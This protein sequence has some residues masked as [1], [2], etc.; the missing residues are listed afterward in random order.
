MD[1]AHATAVADRFLDAEVTAAAVAAA[2]PSA[3]A[4]AVASAAAA[5]RLNPTL[6]R[7]GMPSALVALPSRFTDLYAQLSGRTCPRTHAFPE[8]PAI[9]LLCGALL[10]AGTTCCKRHSVGALTQHVS[11]CGAGV[12]L[13]F[14]LHKCTT[15]LIRGSHAAF[16]CSPYVDEHG[17]E[18]AGLKRGRP[19]TLDPHRMAQLER[20]W[21]SHCIASEV[22]RERV[23]RERVIRENFY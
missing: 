2:T 21:A 16:C 5:A 3:L 20:L 10:C 23:T 22:V 18:D 12:G 6:Q 19:L 8:E 17:E 1:A 15:V 11:T 4:A 9:C 7:P 13:F 14:L